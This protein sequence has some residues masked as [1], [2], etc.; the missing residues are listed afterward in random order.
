[1]RRFSSALSTCAWAEAIAAGEGVVVVVVLELDEL[2]ELEPDDLPE[3]E[4][5]E[6]ELEEAGLCESD[7]DGLEPVDFE[8]VEGVSP[9]L[10]TG[11][12]VGRR[13]VS[14][15]NSVVDGSTVV[16]ALLVLPEPEELE[17]PS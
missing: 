10:V 13:T 16:L 15:T 1:M 4:D 9:V 7:D 12:L 6:S 5:E 17:P 2:P 14:E 3:L 8:W 11:V